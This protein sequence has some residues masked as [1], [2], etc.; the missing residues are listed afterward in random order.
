MKIDIDII[1]STK[2]D[3]KFIKLCEN[4]TKILPF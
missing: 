3:K 2:K 1:N 4:W